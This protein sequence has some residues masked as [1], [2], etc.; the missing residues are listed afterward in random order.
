MV[1]NGDVKAATQLV[2]AASFWASCSIGMTILNKLAVSKTG[3]PLGVV[4]VQMAATCAVAVASGNL[5]FGKGTR[6]WALTI[7]LLF[8]AMM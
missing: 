5:H 7:P 2:L 1:A 4:M 8:V 6:T 3:A